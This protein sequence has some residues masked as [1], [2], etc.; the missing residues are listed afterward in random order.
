MT[1]QQTQLPIEQPALHEQQ[2]AFLRDSLVNHIFTKYHDLVKALK[3]LP[4]NQEVPG[5]TFSYLMIDSAMLW[6]KEILKTSPLTLAAPVESK[7]E[8]NAN[9][10]QPIAEGE[11]HPENLTVTTE[12]I[13]K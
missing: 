4:I 1:E 11:K 2:A 9:E 12:E 8:L 7:E 5:V 10:E 6:F 13:V 3:I